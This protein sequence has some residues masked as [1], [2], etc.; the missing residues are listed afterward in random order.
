MEFVLCPNGKVWALNNEGLISGSVLVPEYEDKE[1]LE[2]RLLAIS[3]AATG[4]QTGL[5]NFEYKYLGDDIVWF[6]GVPEILDNYPEE[7]KKLE[8]TSD[9]VSSALAEQYGLDSMEVEHALD[10]L[11]TQYGAECTL[12]IAGSHRAVHC[13]AA[14][15]E[16]FY[17]RVVVDG[18]ELAYWHMDEWHQA[19][20]EVMGAVLGAARGG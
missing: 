7:C 14:P 19:P 5:T 12:R 10:N 11:D 6:E 8:A 3:E 9:E 2:N 17:V 13:P 4:S 16:C 18:L 20:A 1:T 15:A